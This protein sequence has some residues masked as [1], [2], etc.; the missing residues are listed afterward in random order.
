MLTGNL[1]YYGTQRPRP[2][3]STKKKTQTKKLHCL[4]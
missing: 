2:P 3:P 1:K 4:Q